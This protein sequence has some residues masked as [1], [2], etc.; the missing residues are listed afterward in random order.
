VIHATPATLFSFWPVVLL[1][2]LGCAA[3]QTEMG[4]RLDPGQVGQ[5]IEGKTTETEAIALLGP[6]QHVTERPDGAKILMYSHY[7]TQFSRHPVLPASKG[8]ISSE[9]LF[10]GVRNGLVM[11]KWQSSSNTPLTSSNSLTLSPPK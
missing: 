5:I 3:H 1:T 6:P 11:K 8:G 2:A 10:L 4:K 9:T 7:L